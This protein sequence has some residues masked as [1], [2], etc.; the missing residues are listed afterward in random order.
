MA[1][2]EH[3]YFVD[4]V[5]NIGANLGLST[6]EHVCKLLVVCILM[7]VCNWHTTTFTPCS[8]RNDSSFPKP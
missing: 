7:F 6:Y 4:D 3:K 1:T 2:Q 5:Q 8:T